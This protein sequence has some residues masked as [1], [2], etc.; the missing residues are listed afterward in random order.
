MS[1]WHVCDARMSIDDLADAIYH[2]VLPYLTRITRI[3][4]PGR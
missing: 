3:D 4:A 1:R 2:H